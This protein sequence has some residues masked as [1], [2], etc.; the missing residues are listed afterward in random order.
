MTDANVARWWLVVRRRVL[1]ML[2]M[3]TQ[4]ASSTSRRSVSGFR[5]EKSGSNSVPYALQA[6]DGNVAV[7]PRCFCGVYAIM[8]MSKTVSNPN[9]IFLGCPFYKGKEGHCKFFVWLDEHLI[10]GG[11]EGG[12]EDGTC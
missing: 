6:G 8:Y 4:G 12:C 1:R 2:T 7:A 3:A 11:I 5:E 10:W 9:R